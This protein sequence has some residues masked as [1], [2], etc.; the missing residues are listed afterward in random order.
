MMV[1]DAAK[2]YLLLTALLIASTGL[3]AKSM[4]YTIKLAG[5]TIGTLNT[6]HARVDDIDYY[7]ITSNVEINFLFHVK[8]YYRTLSFYRNNILIESTVNSTVNDSSYVSS[9]IW[10]GHKYKISCNAYQYKYADS[11]RT[12]PIYWSVSKLYFE[13]PLDG[14]EVYAESYGM[15]SPLKKEKDN[16]FRFGIS[17]SKQMYFYNADSLPDKIEV[18]NSI[19]N[20]EIVKNS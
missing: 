19:K 16:Q 12:A 14:T 17:K 20:F 4:S 15:F 18:I 1:V 5:F 7:S 2:K 10:D 13:K 11:S 9:T 3:V 8:I 6:S